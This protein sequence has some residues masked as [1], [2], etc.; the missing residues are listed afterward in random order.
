MCNNNFVKAIR[1]ARTNKSYSQRDLAKLT[2]VSYTYIS[3]F[4]NGRLAYP[5]SEEFLQSLGKHLELDFADLC[6]WAGRI[7]PENE[8]NF[9]EL[10]VT[11]KQMPRLL[12][13]MLNNPVFSETLF[14]E[15]DEIKRS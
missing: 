11:Y 4:E 2:G 10:M 8:K 14:E 13:Q 15:M 1:Q 5:P 12:R 6:F 7:S 3:K 9:K